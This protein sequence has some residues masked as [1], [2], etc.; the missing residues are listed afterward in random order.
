MLPAGMHRIRV[1]FADQFGFARGKYVPAAATTGEVGF[2]VTIFGVGYD[3]DLIPAPGAEVLEGMGDLSALY[4]LDD[5]RPSWDEGT[6]V[7]IADLER[8]GKPLAIS[9]RLAAQ[10]AIDALAA[11]TGGTPKIGVELEAYVLQP[12]GSGGWAPWDTP[13]AYS[14]SWWSATGTPSTPS[15]APS[16]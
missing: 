9:S 6:G 10:R 4:S 2:S 7:V 3:R 11:V 8:Q 15:T 5:V 16:C 12:D 1:L 14:S 13:G